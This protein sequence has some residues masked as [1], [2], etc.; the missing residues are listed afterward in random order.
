M[1]EMSSNLVQIFDNPEFGQVR[2]VMHNGEP[3]F[4]ASDVATALGYAHPGNAVN[5]HC[6]KVNKISQFPASG[7]RQNVPPVTMN[8]IP[9]GDVYRLIIRSNLPSAEKFEIWVMEEVL[10]AI[11]KTGGYGR[12]MPQTFAEALRAYADEVEK[13]EQAE[14]VARGA[15]SRA[16]AA[17]EC[18]GIAGQWQ[19]VKAMDW[20]CSVFDTHG[21]KNP[22]WSQLGHLASRISKQLG[23]ERRPALDSEWGQ[24][25]LYHVD[26]LKAVHAYI[27]GQTAWLAKYRK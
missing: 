1:A 15:L 2:V 12:P 27:M 6:K 22:V 5:A 11:R 24:V 17:E 8:I 3:W 19:Q 21:K 14:L 20:V 7:N 4:V 23:Y 16:E 25:W 26:V 13:R 10:P 18:I 9:E